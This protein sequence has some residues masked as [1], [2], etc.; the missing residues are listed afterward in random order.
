MPSSSLYKHRK[1]N[2]YFGRTANGSTATA[3]VRA[4]NFTVIAPSLI[5]GDIRR[6]TSSCC[7]RTALMRNSGTRSLEN[8]S[9]D[10][11]KGCNAYCVFRG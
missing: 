6:T 11:G 4:K 7:M 3:A 9:V 1:L 2:G 8:K 5:I 10:K